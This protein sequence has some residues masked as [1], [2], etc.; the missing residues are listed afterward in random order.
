MSKVLEVQVM[1]DYKTRNKMLAEIE[2][3][4]ALSGLTRAYFVCVLGIV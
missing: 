1:I 3:L 4:K 2:S